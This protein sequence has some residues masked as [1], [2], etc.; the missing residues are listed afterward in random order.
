MPRPAQPTSLAKGPR[1]L[2]RLRDNDASARLQSELGPATPTDS[3]VVQ[4]HFGM[5]T[6]SLRSKVVAIDSASPDYDTNSS[7]TR[8]DC[9]RDIDG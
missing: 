9:P 4:T 7:N 3:Q 2:V 6:Y 8:I 1:G 5:V